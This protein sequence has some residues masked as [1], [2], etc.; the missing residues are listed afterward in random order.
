MGFR[1]LFP[2]FCFA[3]GMLGFPALVR[4]ELLPQ[5][6]SLLEAHAPNLHTSKP[7]DWGALDLGVAKSA[8]V[9]RT[10]AARGT[11]RGGRLG[12]HLLQD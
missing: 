4:E 6:R 3:G 11:R 10:D 12:Q 8:R 9:A 5:G 1:N 7:R 2:V